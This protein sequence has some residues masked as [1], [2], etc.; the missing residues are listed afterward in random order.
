MQRYSNQTPLQAL[1][2]REWTGIHKLCLR[3]ETALLPE[4]VQGSVDVTADL[5]AVVKRRPFQV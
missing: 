3:E 5:P 2:F 4:G 1:K